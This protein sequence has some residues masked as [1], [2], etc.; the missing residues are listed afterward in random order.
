MCEGGNVGRSIADTDTPISANLDHDTNILAI[1]KEIALEYI[2]V[3]IHST[4]LLPPRLYRVSR[5][6]TLAQCLKEYE[7]ECKKLN[8]QF[9]NL[10]FYSF[11]HTINTEEEEQNLSGEWVASPWNDAEP[12][13]DNTPALRFHDMGI[14]LA[15]EEAE[16]QKYYNSEHSLFWLQHALDH[17]VVDDALTDYDTE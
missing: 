13:F 6:S 2:T 10:Q 8:F 14:V 12:I 5:L 11:E 15:I 1:E 3:Q 7:E 16:I 17:F 9:E 4:R